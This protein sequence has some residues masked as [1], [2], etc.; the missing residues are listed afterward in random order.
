M[1]QGVRWSCSTGEKKVV[2]IQ[3]IQV[4]CCTHCSIVF[5]MQWVFPIFSKEHK[6]IHQLKWHRKNPVPNRDFSERQREISFGSTQ[7][8]GGEEEVRLFLGICFSKGIYHPYCIANFLGSGSNLNS[9]AE[10]KCL[11]DMNK[12]VCTNRISQNYRLPL[13]WGISWKK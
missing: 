8:A 5:N 13:M 11:T 12:W 2:A 6:P 3:P 4:H 7:G 10:I 9:K 1:L